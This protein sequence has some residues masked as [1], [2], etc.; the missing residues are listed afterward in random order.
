MTAM[1]GTARLAMGV[2]KPPYVVTAL[3]RDFLTA[4]DEKQV[5]ENPEKP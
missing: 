2:S 3:C 5:K 4:C 1:T